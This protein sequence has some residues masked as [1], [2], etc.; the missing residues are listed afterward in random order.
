MDEKNLDAFNIDIKLAKAMTAEYEKVRTGRSGNIKKQDTKYVY[1][2]RK[3]LLDYINKYPNAKGIRVY[4]GVIG[5]YTVDGIKFP[6]KT[7]FEKQLTVILKATDDPSFINDPSTPLIVSP[8][9]EAGYDPEDDFD[10]C[11]PAFS[12]NGKCNEIYE[13]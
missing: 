7:E 12:P 3:K 8:L 11:P 9:N 13:S 5:D 2:P 10:I 6:F 4:F 1:I